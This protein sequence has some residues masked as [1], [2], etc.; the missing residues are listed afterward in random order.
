MSDLTLFTDTTTPAAAPPAAAGV[1]TPFVH[2]AAIISS[3]ETAWREIRRR[4]TGV[5]GTSVTVPPTVGAQDLTECTAR[6]TG[7]RFERDGHLIME[8]Q[9]SSGTL[10]LGATRPGRSGRFGPYGSDTGA[11]GDERDQAPAEPA[12][13]VPGR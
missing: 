8:L 4:F 9:V 10:G 13:D 11:E 3:V 6:R 1:T 2:G 5:P 7:R 12:E